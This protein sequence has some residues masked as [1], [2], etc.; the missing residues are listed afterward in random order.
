[1]PDAADSATVSAREIADAVLAV[2]GVTGLHGG[3]FGEIATYLPGGRVS[4][5]VV[6]DD[7]VDVHV[8][9]DMAHDLRSVAEQV[10]DVATRI[11]GSPVSVTVEDISVRSGVGAEAGGVDNGDGDNEIDRDPVDDNRTDPGDSGLPPVP[12]SALPEE[13][14]K[15]V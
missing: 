15:H 7:S 11:A 9:V 13:V 1:M 2:D 8:V 12:G 10:R 3:V 6:G 14:N 4:G 5:V